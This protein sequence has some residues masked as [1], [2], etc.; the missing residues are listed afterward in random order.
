VTAHAARR[1]PELQRFY[2]RK[3]IQRG[4]GNQAQNRGEPS[5]GVTERT[6]GRAQ[7]V[8]ITIQALSLRRATRL[9]ERSPSHVYDAVSAKTACERTLEFVKKALA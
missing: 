6:G 1:D 5:H 2:L 8:E 9:H 7:A 3:L 4:L